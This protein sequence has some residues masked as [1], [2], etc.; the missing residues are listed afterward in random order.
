MRIV[1]AGMMMLATAGAL[2][3]QEPSAGV[4]PQIKVVTG[5]TF[6]FISE[7][8]VGGIPVKGAPYSAQAVTETTQTLADGNRIV[9]K[10]TAMVYR[11]SLGRERREQTLPA[12]GPFTAQGDAPQI[13]SIF[14]PVA[15]VN[16][17]LNPR[18]HIA[19]KLPSPPSPPSP[20]NL[21]VTKEFKEFNVTVSGS[22]PGIQTAP[23][24]PTVL[25]YRGPVSPNSKEP[26]KVE[27]LGWRLVEGL[28]AEGTRT[29]ITIPAGQIGNDRPIE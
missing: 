29:T 1:T 2:H 11:D 15:G 27:Q 14:D 17:S 16:Y 8:L 25:F 4:L 23:A 24:L 3:A 21:G 7:Q 5:G 26:P 6:G 19:M 9:Q 10:S 20:P 18:E 13:I 12:I 28:Q 22:G